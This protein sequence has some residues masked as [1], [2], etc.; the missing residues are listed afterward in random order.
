MKGVWF[1]FLFGFVCFL[2]YLFGFGLFWFGFLIFVCV[3]VCVWFL[4]WFGVGFFLFVWLFVFIFF[5]FFK[6]WRM[7]VH[8][9]KEKDVNQQFS[10]L[11]YSG[12]QP[13][14]YRDRTRRNILKL[15]QK[16]FILDIKENFF[17]QR[18]A[19][20]W[21]SRAAVEFPSM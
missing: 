10:F 5:F 18:V 4:V 21:L 1:Y 9:W 6:F 20:P 13:L 2:V 3:C 14:V 19:K 16:G 8:V 17:I 15:S 11:L 12:W 7:Y